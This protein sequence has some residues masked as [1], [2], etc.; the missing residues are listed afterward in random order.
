MN[1][2]C[3]FS[4]VSHLTTVIASVHLALTFRPTT[5]HK[6]EDPILSEIT[7]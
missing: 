7:V 1:L 4:Y 3:V 6:A 2:G 5:T